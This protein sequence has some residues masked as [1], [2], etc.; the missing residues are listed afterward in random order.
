M[1]KHEQVMTHLYSLIYHFTWKRNYAMTTRLSLDTIG[2]TFNAATDQDPSCSN[3]QPIFNTLPRITNCAPA[4]NHSFHLKN[5]H[6][7][8][9]AQ[10]GERL[11][12]EDI[13]VKF[14]L[15]HGQWPKKRAA[16]TR[17]ALVLLQLKPVSGAKWNSRRANDSRS[18][19]RRWEDRQPYLFMPA[20]PPSD[21]RALL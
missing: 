4:A 20:C 21:L 14:S 12:G 13:V 17:W 3:W 15:I 11:R 6:S 19:Q 8:V 9:L 16:P 10:L 1:H 18:T 5:K 7:S 2:V